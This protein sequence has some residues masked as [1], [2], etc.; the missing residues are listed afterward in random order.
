VVAAIGCTDPGDKGDVD[1][2][3]AAFSPMGQRVIDTLRTDHAAARGKTW[4]LGIDN[5]LEPGW[6]VQTPLGSYWDK[7]VTALPVTTACT[8]DAACDPDFGLLACSTQN[9]CKY[10]GTCSEVAATVN[11]PGDTP[12]RL[13]IG[14]SD[15]IYDRIYGL[16]ARAKS[17]VEIASLGPADGRFET[18]LR[19]AITFLS[20][21]GR[22]VRVRFLW[23]AIPGAEL[24]GA[25]LPPADVLASLVRDIDRTSPIRVAVGAL[26]ATLDSWTHTKMVAIDG[27]TALVG[28]HNMWTHHYLQQAPAFDLSMQVSGSAALQATRFAEQ[29]WHATCHT[30]L[31]LFAY[32]SISGFPDAT[33]GCGEPPPV[34]LAAHIGHTNVLSVGRLGALGDN[35]ADDALIA[36]MD[37]A[38]TRLRISQQDIGPVGRDLA[39]PDPV[40]RSFV[41][42]L[43]RGVEIDLVMTNLNALP[44][45]LT[46]GSAAYSNGWTPNDVI[47]ALARYAAAHPELAADARALICSG[48]HVATLRLGP[49]NAWPDGATFGNHVKLV[50]ADDQAFYIGSQNLYPS[51]LSEYGYIVDGGDAVR[52]VEIEYWSKAWEA[53][54]RTEVPCGL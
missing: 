48:F 3:E 50:L 1:E 16:V 49:D 9:D 17:S 39:W 26:R 47:A 54:R 19:N 7:P 13:C 53:S 24:A 20:R 6:I 32:T 43:A 44:G 33:V 38:T 30:P 4:D 34:D 41:S 51:N 21:S 22:S 36:L 15:E 8:G 52:D 5:S 45:G 23:G 37:G 10:G 40:L 27:Q 31:D 12:R 25:S 28:G 14:H 46:V 29:L 11:H 2:L 42:A 35:A 18:A